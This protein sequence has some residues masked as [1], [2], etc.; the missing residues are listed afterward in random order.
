MNIK[1]IKMIITETNNRYFTMKYNKVKR[2]IQTFLFV[3][4]IYLFPL[5]LKAQDVVQAGEFIVEPSTLTNLGFE[6]KI[7]GDENR[8]ASVS[9]EYRAVG[10]QQWKEALPLL[11]MGDERVILETEYLD[12]TVPN[13]FAG[14]ILDVDIDTE[15]ECR[16]TMK[17]PD[18]AEGDIVKNVKVGTHSEPK[19]EA[20]RRVLYVHT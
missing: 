20:G 18:K 1:N 12:Y 14:S 13:M 16:F 11:R 7:T 4:L 2:I 10:T 6:W 5:T 15:Y 8:N 17:D 3:G 19:D 9:V